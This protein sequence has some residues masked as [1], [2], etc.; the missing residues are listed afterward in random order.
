MA[1]VSRRKQIPIEGAITTRHRS[2]RSQY[3]A[4]KTIRNRNPGKRVRKVKQYITRAL[5]LRAVDLQARRR[6]LRRMSTGIG[7]VDYHRRVRR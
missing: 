2:R 7:H 5:H 6:G 1:R 3:A 4:V